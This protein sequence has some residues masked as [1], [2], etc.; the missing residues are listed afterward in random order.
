MS[1][2]RGPKVQHG[3]RRGKLLEWRMVSHREQGR[4]GEAE[5]HKRIGFVLKRPQSSATSQAEG[6][7][8]V[9]S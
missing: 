6:T 9:G 2:V 3:V 8:A 4:A 5:V 1:V 7:S